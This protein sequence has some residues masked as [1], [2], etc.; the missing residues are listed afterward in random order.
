MTVDVALND[1]AERSLHLECATP[2]IA[3]QPR[4]GVATTPALDRQ[5]ASFLRTRVAKSVAHH[6]WPPQRAA[7]PVGQRS[8]DAF[9][10]CRETH[11]R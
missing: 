10:I 3:T 9:K 4:L 2:L 11:E 8:E 1:R 5:N 6:G 7:D